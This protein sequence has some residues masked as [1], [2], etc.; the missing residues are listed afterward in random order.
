MLESVT[1]SATKRP[2]SLFPPFKRR[3]WLKTF[4]PN[5]IC[6]NLSLAQSKRGRALILRLG[7]NLSFFCWLGWTS[8]REPPTEMWRFR[9][10][11]SRWISSVELR[12][13]LQSR[14]SHSWAL[15]KLFKIHYFLL[16]SDPQFYVPTTVTEQQIFHETVRIIWLFL[17][18]TVDLHLPQNTDRKSAQRRRVRGHHAAGLSVDLVVMATQARTGT[19]RHL[20]SSTY[21]SPLRSC[22]PTLVLISFNNHS[23]CSGIR[24]EAKRHNHQ[25]S[26]NTLDEETWNFETEVLTF[27]SNSFAQSAC[28]KQ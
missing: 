16:K 23:G 12:R 19:V 5:L 9:F 22:S 13:G 26:R 8:R 6:I 25:V 11:Q 7:C 20:P 27:S 24:K 10:L 28:K 14:R 4:F 15:I 1:N 17:A 18:S 3:D 21:T 2:R